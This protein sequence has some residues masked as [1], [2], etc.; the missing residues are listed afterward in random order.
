MFTGPGH[1]QPGRRRHK[2]DPRG[3]A[4]KQFKAFSCVCCIDDEDVF[5]RGFS[6][7]LVYCINSVCHTLQVPVTHG[8]LRRW[9]EGPIS[10]GAAVAGETVA[11]QTS[12]AEGRGVTWLKQ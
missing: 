12:K 10:G 9:D 7:W 8:A 3:S 1:V 11:P 5:C 2:T 4:S 6:W